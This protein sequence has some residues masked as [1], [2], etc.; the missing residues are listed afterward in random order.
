VAALVKKYENS[1]LVKT[2]EQ[3]KEERL[4][5]RRGGR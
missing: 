4:K 2:L 5:N 3:L 1:G